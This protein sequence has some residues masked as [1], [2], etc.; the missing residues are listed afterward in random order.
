MA[1]KLGNLGMVSKS[2]PLHQGRHLD[3]FFKTVTIYSDCNHVIEH[4]D[5]LSEHL[6]LHLY[7]K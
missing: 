2:G 7:P 6:E 5:P 1:G 3:K 4:I